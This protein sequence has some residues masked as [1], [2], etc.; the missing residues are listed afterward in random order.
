MLRMSIIGSYIGD[1]R[2]MSCTAGPALAQQSVATEGLDTETKPA[3]QSGATALIE[4][5]DITDE[6][7][8]SVSL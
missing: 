6:S 1:E 5:S 2:V 7:V 8:E 3:G 4:G